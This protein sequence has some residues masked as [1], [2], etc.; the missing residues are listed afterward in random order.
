MHRGPHCLLHCTLTEPST[1]KSIHLLYC[2]NRDVWG[3]MCLKQPACVSLLLGILVQFIISKEANELTLEGIDTIAYVGVDSGNFICTWNGAE[4]IT[5]LEWYIEGLLGLGLGQH[6]TDRSIALNVKSTTNS[7]GKRYICK[8]TTASGS[9]VENSFNIMVKEIEYEFSI[10]EDKCKL[11]NCLTLTCT[12][13]CNAPVTVE[14]LYKNEN[15]V[16]NTSTITVSEQRTLSF[17]NLK[18]RNITFKPLLLS[19]KGIYVCTLR[20]KTFSRQ[21]S[22]SVN[23]S[24][25]S[26]L[27]Q[28][29]PMSGSIIDINGVENITLFCKVGNDELVQTVWLLLTNNPM[30]NGHKPV[31]VLEDDRFILTGDIIVSDGVNTSQNSNMTIV[32][33]PTELEESV[34]FC[35]TADSSF[36]GNFTLIAKI[37]EKTK[38]ICSIST[39]KT[40]A[41][42][43]VKFSSQG[44]P[45][46]MIVIKIIDHPELCCNNITAY[47]RS[48]T[49]QLEMDG[50]SEGTVYR[51]NLFVEN[52]WGRGPEMKFFFTTDSNTTNNSTTD[53][54]TTNSS[55]TDCNTT[56]S[57]TADNNATDSDTRYSE[58]SFFPSWLKAVISVCCF[59]I[60]S[61]FSLI[62]CNVIYRIYE[63]DMSKIWRIILLK[64]PPQVETLPEEATNPS[65]VTPSH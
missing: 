61:I 42:I 22:Y 1:G 48:D 34:L 8:A 53:N 32:E 11:F 43:E 26:R 3:E 41:V 45:P 18:E 50:L 29:Y 16:V 38:R 39:T 63:V 13:W 65:S 25:I 37:H 55:T 35:G 17:I 40:T 9:I 44:T 21:Q 23:S 47:R 15:K 30:Q 64:S 14:W 2:C 19:H 20:Y 4:N 28:V 51:A 24:R 57:N 62:V 27:W 46:F 7:N 31:N 6:I 54:N 58:S 52:R 59:V 36:L 60:L 12:V 10:T 49:V 33:V 5:K 56:D